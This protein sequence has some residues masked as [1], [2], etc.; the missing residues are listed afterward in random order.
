MS[1]KVVR[2]ANVSGSG[3]LY[4]KN[5]QCWALAKNL[6]IL[7]TRNSKELHEVLESFIEIASD[8]GLTVNEAKINIGIGVMTGRKLIDTEWSNRMKKK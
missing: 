2:K 6:A 5:H 4:H 1:E 8:V 3:L 7:I